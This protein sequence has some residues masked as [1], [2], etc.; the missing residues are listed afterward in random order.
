VVV[1]QREEQDLRERIRVLEQQK[2]DLQAHA[3]M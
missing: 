2:V 3:F 1:A